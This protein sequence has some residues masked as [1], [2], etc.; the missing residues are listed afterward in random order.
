LGANNLR[1]FIDCHARADISADAFR[2]ALEA[3]EQQRANAV[4]ACP[5]DYLVVPGGRIFCVVEAPGPAAVQRLH[6]ELG[7]PAP[8]VSLLEG[9]EGASPLSDH[10]RDLILRQDLNGRR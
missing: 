9:A 10:D 2:R 5:I 1:I 4:G 8:T 3:A 6:D 7:L